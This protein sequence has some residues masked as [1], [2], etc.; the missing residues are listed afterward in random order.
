MVLSDGKTIERFLVVNKVRPASKQKKSVMYSCR[1][2]LD[3]V[4]EAYYN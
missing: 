3:N 1:F 4:P 2:D